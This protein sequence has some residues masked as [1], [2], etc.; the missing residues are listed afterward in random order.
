MIEDNLF[1]KEPDF[2]VSPDG[3][4]YLAILSIVYDSWIMWQDAI[5]FDSQDRLKM[6]QEIYTNIVSLATKIHKLHQSFPNYKSL[7]EPPFEFVL[8]WDPLD[9]DPNWN[10]GKY[11]RFMI[12]GFE[13]ADI[14]H[15]NSLK[16]NSYLSIKP[17]TR[18]LVEVTLRT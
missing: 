14:I 13:S 12:D 2:F 10:S 15:Y 11:C 9:K 7:T 5:P 18:R 6:T 17:L 8:W 16:K 4:K 3:Q 1:E